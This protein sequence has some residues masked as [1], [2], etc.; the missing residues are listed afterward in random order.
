MPEERQ[1]LI[2]NL[3]IGINSG[4]V[5][6]AGQDAYR[7]ASVFWLQRPLDLTSGIYS[8]E[9]TERVALPPDTTD[10]PNIL[11]NLG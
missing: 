1:G 9:S 2:D 10:F 5:W 4:P 8:Q 6:F 7:D 3:K 11:C